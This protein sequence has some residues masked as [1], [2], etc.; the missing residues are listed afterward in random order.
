MAKAEGREF[1]MT[2]LRTLYEDKK[3]KAGIFEGL[4]II[5]TQI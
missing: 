3:I 2:R 1:Y 4:K 5:V